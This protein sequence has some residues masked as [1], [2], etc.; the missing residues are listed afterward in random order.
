MAACDAHSDSKGWWTE[1]M[2][3]EITAHSMRIATGLSLGN[4][5]LGDDRW[6]CCIYKTLIL[7]FMVV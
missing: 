4:H 6:K 1:E 5:G 7:S 2:N 3:G